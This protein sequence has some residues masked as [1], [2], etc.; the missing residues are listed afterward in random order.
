MLYFTTKENLKTLVLI[1]LTSLLLSGYL[2]T[3]DAGVTDIK[4]DNIEITENIQLYSNG[5]LI[6]EWTGIGR[7]QMS[8]GTYIF[9]TERGA[10]SNEVRISGDFIIETTNR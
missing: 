2:K 4:N 3:D 1:V 6:G 7:G 5:R 8:G 10:F 9:K